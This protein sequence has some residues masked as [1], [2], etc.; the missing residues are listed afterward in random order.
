MCI[1]AAPRACYYKR[2]NLSTLSL[3]AGCL[4][5]AITPAQAQLGNRLARAA[6]RGAERALERKAEQKAAEAVDKTVDGALSKPAPAENPTAERDAPGGRAGGASGGQGAASPDGD[7]D[8]PGALGAAAAAEPVFS[9]TSKYDFEPGAQLLYYDDFSRAAVGDFPTGFNTLGSA[10]VVTTSTAPG[11]WLQVGKQTGGVH[12]M[13][14]PA[15]PGDFTLEFDVIHDLPEEGYRYA[16]EL[17]ILFTD[18]A[19]PEADLNEYMRVGT[20]CASFWIDR[21]ISR[22]WSSDLSKWVKGGELVSGNAT[23]L[24][25]HFSDATRGTPQHVAI[26]RQG[27]R[28]RMYVNDRKVFDVPLAWPDTEPIGGLRLFAR[29]SVDEDRYLVSNFRLAEGAPDTRSKLITEG[30]LTTY[31]ITFASGSAEVEASSAG[32]LKMIAKV[33]EENGDMKLKITG[34]TDADGSTESNQALSEKRAA[35]VKT[36]LVNDYRIATDRLSTAGAG[37]SEPLATGESPSDKAKNRRVV[38]EV[39]PS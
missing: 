5:L 13:E 35:A 38:L 28:M 2:F 32:T 34:H 26:W 30:K 14:S 6:Q 8:E 11:K 36:I 29:M 7:A 17:G 27:R 15:L 21:D 3:V 19:N 10:E 18:L 23:D 39:T 20:K 31:G 22:G 25:A 16:A 9:V 1:S 4:L 12:F 33:L 24:G 37:E